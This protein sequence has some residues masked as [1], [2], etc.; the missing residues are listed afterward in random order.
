M[1]DLPGTQMDGAMGSLH[2]ILARM[3][4]LNLAEGAKVTFMEEETASQF[5]RATSSFPLPP[6]ER[7]KVRG[8]RD[9]PK[10]PAQNCACV[11]YFTSSTFDA[12]T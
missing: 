11:P 1:A 10:N 6:R 9:A 3:G 8:F 5:Q 2:S 7:K 12:A 4:T